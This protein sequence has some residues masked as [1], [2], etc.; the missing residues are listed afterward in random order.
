[1]NMQ[2]VGAETLFAAQTRMAV[3]QQTVAEH[4]AAIGNRESTHEQHKEAAMRENMRPSDFLALFPNPPATV[5]TVEHFNQMR[6]ITGPVD[7]IP[8]ELQAVQSHPDFKADYQALEDYFRN[9]ESPQRP[10]TAEE[11]AT[12]YPAP[13]HTADQATIDAGQTEINALHAFLKSGP[14]PLPGLYDVDLLTNTEVSYP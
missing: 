13:S 9:V 11:F 5:L 7:L 3:L 2:Q 8:P 6:E 1:M 14:N 4:Q 10:I 12:L